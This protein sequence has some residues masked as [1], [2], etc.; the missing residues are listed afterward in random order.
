MVTITKQEQ[1]DIERE[2]RGQSKC[3]QWFR[4]RRGRLTSSNFGKICKF[5]SERVKRAYA[6]SLFDE[7][8]DFRYRP[9]AVQYGLDHERGGIRRY[10]ETKPGVVCSPRGLL[11]PDWKGYAWLGA[12]VDGK[13]REKGGAGGCLEV[14]TLFDEN[15]AS[16]DEVYRK[17]KRTGF[18]LVKLDGRFK[19]KATH[20][21]YYQVQGQ[22]AIYEASFCDF[23]VYHPP[24]RQ[25]VVDRIF[26]DHHFWRTVVLPKLEA[27]YERYVIPLLA[28]GQPQ[29]AEGDEEEKSQAGPVPNLNQ[30]FVQREGVR[31]CGAPKL[32]AVPKDD[33]TSHYP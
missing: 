13:V 3:P 18:Y 31:R 11:V 15:A 1:R 33:A 21:Y 22:L 19:L 25:I 24:S 17:R 14:K 2:T 30:S 12:S 28:A 27:F 7:R 5:R 23:V 29:Y 26:P 20:N 8:V 9:R 10:L 32:Y 6:R 16:I 4:R